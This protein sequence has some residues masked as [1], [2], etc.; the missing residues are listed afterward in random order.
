VTNPGEEARS[1][2][3]APAAA[4]AASQLTEPVWARI[5]RH[6][7][8]E[9][10][11]AYVAFAYAALHGVQMLREAFEWPLLVSRLT[12]FALVL[13]APL[14]VTL[15]WYHG[16]RARHRISGQEL[17]IL[18]VLLLVAGSALWW[19]SKNSHER[20]TAPTGVADTAG[21]VPAFTPP[22]HSIAVL[23]F[24]NMSGDK[25]QEY[26]SDGL[27][28]EILNS[29]ARISELQVSART[30]SFSFKGK[31]VDVGTIAH[32]LNV[33]SILEGS[34]RRSSNTIRVTAQLNSAITGFHLWSQ[35]Y[36]R[37]LRD[38]LQLQTEIASAVATALKV[39][40]LR[41]VAAK[42]ELGGT[43]DP[44]ALDWYLR[45]SKAYN[46]SH[47]SA[48]LQSAANAYSE[49]IHQDPQF[50]LAFAGRAE[51][52]N[53]EASE[54]LG[55]PAAWEQHDKALAD[56][57]QALVLAP[58][59]AEAHL[60]LGTV[61]EEGFLDFNRAAGEYAHARELAPGSARVMKAYGGMAVNMGRLESGLAALQHAIVLD[62]LNTR[63]RS[64]L[65]EAYWSA[66]QYAQSLTTFN[67]IIVLDP[68]WGR[69]RA[70]RGFAYYALG[71][72]DSA[73]S[74]CE[75]RVDD[76][77]NRS[78]L[79]LVYHKLGRH[80]DAKTILAEQQALIGDTA[81]YQYAEIYTQ[82]GDVTKA[83]EWLG[84][85]VRVRDPGLTWLKTDP[86]LDPV[87][88]EPWFRAIEREL[89]FPD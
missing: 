72:F 58:D 10:T 24:V 29:L 39:A 28:E 66:R 57:R 48:D 1:T 71:D 26:F 40:L 30:S 5:K 47:N 38:V 16:H 3:D 63:I 50:A 36:D 20:A 6:K 32:K 33:A 75:A 89:K 86:F 77:W 79:A 51:A 73:R 65:G 8:V 80:G 21:I 78:C 54:W 49:A 15:A 55:G 61:L 13:G 70:W 37:D 74:S 9:W 68:E 35:T 84:R 17:S 83:R 53:R 64:R 46:A 87:R 22:P 82:W 27:T 43:R 59:L 85:A 18:I 7:V 52:L 60:V 25:E 67:D 81:A 56:A 31:D 62:P 14:A 2:Q 45:A 41:D 4:Q 11:L 69:A 88:K 12:V 34:V 19:V 44:A 42:I 23:P 76:G